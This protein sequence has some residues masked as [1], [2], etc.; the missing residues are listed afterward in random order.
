[1]VRNRRGSRASSKDQARLKVYLKPGGTYEKG[2]KTI[3]KLTE[4]KTVKKFPTEFL[5]C[6]RNG[7]K[8][9]DTIA[10]LY[11]TP[12]EL[13][14]NLADNDDGILIIPAPKMK[15]KEAKRVGP[16]QMPK[17]TTKRAG[18]TPAMVDHLSTLGLIPFLLL[19][20]S[21]VLSEHVQGLFWIA[22]DAIMAARPAYPKHEPGRSATPAYHFGIWSL[23]MLRPL[24][25]TE[26]RQSTLSP[27]RQQVLVPLIDAFLRLV[28]EYM[29]PK[30]RRLLMKY[31]P[32][33]IEILAPVYERVHRVLASEL[34]DRPAL[35]FGGLFFVV[36]VKEGSSEFI[37][38]DFNDPLA[39]VT[40][41]W[42]VSRP[43]STWTGGE[44][45]APQLKGKV[46]FRGGQMLA[47]RTRL[48]AHCGATVTGNGRLVLTCFSDST[49]LEHTLFGRANG[50]ISDC[51]VLL[52]M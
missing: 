11:P 26:T 27:N 17:Y 33:Q 9:R 34:A 24:I 6:G 13:L 21:D 1:M 51:V 15:P 42:V 36:A 19:R 4:V 7:Q 44:F 18:M 3:Q 29:V 25:T 16:A 50:D 43:G 48:L 23:F 12:V 39:L 47:V 10:E 8:V 14:P 28:Q 37:H 2:Q 22:W 38:I 5:T 45:C 41:I 30:A 49:L 46:S 20:C 32:Q 52:D 40:L 35:D 31:A